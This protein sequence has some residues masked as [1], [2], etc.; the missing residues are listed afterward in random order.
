MNVAITKK[1]PGALP[2]SVQ[3]M[4]NLLSVRFPLATGE[5]EITQQEDMMSENFN[6]EVSLYKDSPK[7]KVSGGFHRMLSGGFTAGTR[8][9]FLAR[10]KNGDYLF[11]LNI[12]G[13]GLSTNFMEV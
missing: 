13:V 6:G 5:I 11:E 2:T 1:E 10:E 7:I 4:E 9:Y 3:I 12:K 8:L